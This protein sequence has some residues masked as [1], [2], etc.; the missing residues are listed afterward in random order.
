MTVYQCRFCKMI[1]EANT[2]TPFKNRS[3]ASA[4]EFELKL[5]SEWKV[6][7][8][9]YTDDEVDCVFIK[10][11]ENEKIAFGKRLKYKIA[12]QTCQRCERISGGYYEAI[13]QL[14]GDWDR[15]NNLIAK[16]TKY[17]ERGTDSSRR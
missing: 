3:F 2:F 7:V 10:N 12:R 4:I 1:K 13:L 16:V 8:K 9:E 11:Y 6:K 15:I 14:R 17:V 5:N